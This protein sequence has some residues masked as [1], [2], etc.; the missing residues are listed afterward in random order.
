MSVLVISVPAYEKSA[1]SIESAPTVTASP[2]DLL[3]MPFIWRFMLLAPFGMERL[4]DC[5]WTCAFRAPN[6]SA[7]KRDVFVCL[8]LTRPDLLR[9]I[10][11]A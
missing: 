7:V 5:F 8:G 1:V 11:H 10:I 6:N 2:C 4:S 3:T 9:G